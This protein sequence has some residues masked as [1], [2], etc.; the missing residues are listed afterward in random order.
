MASNWALELN[1]VEDEDAALRQAIAMSLGEAVVDQ[2]NG[3]GASKHNA[4]AI[5]QEA[6][7]ESEPAPTE[8]TTTNSMSALGLDRKKM[9]EERLARLK[10]R[11]AQSITND[12]NTTAYHSSETPARRPKLGDPNPDYV[13]AAAKA[14][15]NST[16]QDHQRVSKFPYAKGTVLRTYARGTPRN[17]DV[18]IEEV[19]QKD[20]LELAVLS[21]FQWDEEWL[22]TK[23][24][25]RKTKVLMIAFA[26]DEAQVCRRTSSM[27]FWGLCPPG[28]RSAA[29]PATEEG[30]ARQCA[31][32]CDPLCLSANGERCQHY[33]LE[34]SAFEIP[35]AS[36]HCC[37]DRK[38]C[39][40]RLGRD[41]RHGK[42]TVP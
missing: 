2:P 41:R 27:H 39:S 12:T 21:S 23:L 16:S 33:A 20:E 19:L 8:P 31:L 6:E 26:A 1:G 9:E 42:C 17:R 38:P 40:L 7:L 3:G 15:T 32:G 28:S 24:D 37:A 25:L 14:P 10:K 29:D 35:E 11:K 34:T 4:T 18:T 13:F 30:N 22:M 5:I 36:A